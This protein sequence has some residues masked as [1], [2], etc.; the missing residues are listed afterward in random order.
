MNRNKKMKKTTIV[1]GILLVTSSLCLGQL[2]SSYNPFSSAVEETAKIKSENDKEI[3]QLNSR[4]NQLK[5]LDLEIEK[6]LKTC[7]EQ[8]EL[9]KNEHPKGEFEKEDDYKRRIRE[10]EYIIENEKAA[11]KTKLSKKSRLERDIE[12]RKNKIKGFEVPQDLSI[13]S[14]TLWIASIGSYDS[15]KEQFSIVVNSENFVVNIPIE[16]ARNFKENYKS[17]PIHKYKSDFWCFYNNSYYRLHQYSTIRISGRDYATIKIGDNWW[18]AENLGFK[19]LNSIRYLTLPEGWKI[20]S[21]EDWKDLLTYYSYNKS[22]KRIFMNGGDLGINFPYYNSYINDFLTRQGEYLT[23]TS[24]TQCMMDKG[25]V[26]IV[27]V[28]PSVVQYGEKKY[29][30]FGVRLVKTTTDRIENTPVNEEAKVKQADSNLPKLNVSEKRGILTING[31]GFRFLKMNLGSKYL[32]WNVND[33]VIDGKSDFTFEEA[34]VIADLI[35]GWRLPTQHEYKRMLTYLG[36]NTGSIKTHVSPMAY[37]MFTR[38]SI[39]NATTDVY[40]WTA[41]SENNDESNPRAF[42]WG[43]INKE[44]TRASLNKTSTHKLRLVKE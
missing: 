29:F 41:T 35:D 9:L 16:K 13:P 3:S 15:E 40:Y 19:D 24:G 17:Q 1:I 14:D 10:R 7:N 6:D 25:G 5:T 36:G 20:P 31:Q 38:K 42:V 33:I 8:I 11:L 26:G 27:N 18:M 12:I 32:P 43:A 34:K 21:V 22:N 30:K 37:R 2:Q 44:I 39:F 28:S 23:A 4:I